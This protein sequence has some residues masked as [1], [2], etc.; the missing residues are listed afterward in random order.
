MTFQIDELGPMRAEEAVVAAGTPALP[1]VKG[2][3]H[4][5]SGCSILKDRIARCGLKPN[6]GSAF[7]IEPDR[8]D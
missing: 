3:S 8:C 7:G 5:E 2:T 1:E 6:L 4:L